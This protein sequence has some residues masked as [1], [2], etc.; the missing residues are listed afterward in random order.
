MMVIIFTVV[1]AS[2]GVYLVYSQYQVIRLGY[3]IDQ[4]LAEYRRQLETVK[5]LELSIASYK[6]PKAV[7]ALAEQELDMRVP[8]YT[9]E[10][11]VPDPAKGKV[12][13][14]LPNLESPQAWLDEGEAG[15]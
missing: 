1:T 2:M 14:R 6:H 4:D 5:R 7:T 3:V 13:P 9:E 8:H 12:R 11:T 15:R 10:F